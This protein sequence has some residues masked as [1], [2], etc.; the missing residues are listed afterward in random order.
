MQDNLAVAKFSR[1]LGIRTCNYHHDALQKSC[2]KLED[3]YIKVVDLVSAT[4]NLY[5]L[6]NLSKI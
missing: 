3:L 4:L 6:L 2:S 5:H 1:D